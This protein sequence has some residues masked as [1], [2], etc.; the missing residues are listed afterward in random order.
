MRANQ[1]AASLEKA[2]VSQSFN[3]FC[4][5]G[6]KVWTTYGDGLAGQTLQMILLGVTMAMQV[7]QSAEF[8][9]A[10]ALKICICFPVRSGVW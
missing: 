2:C 9:G 1:Y 8:V 6:L 10:K 4:V 3:D 5:R 7:D